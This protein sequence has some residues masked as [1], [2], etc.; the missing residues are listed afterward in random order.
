MFTAVTTPIIWSTP[1]LVSFLHPASYV[2]YNAVRSLLSLSSTLCASARTVEHELVEARVRIRRGERNRCCVRFVATNGWFV[3]EAL[4]GVL[5]G[6]EIRLNV[7]SSPHGDA[8]PTGP[9]IGVAIGA[10]T[11]TA[12][13]T[14]TATG[15]VG[16]RDLAPRDDEDDP[17]SQHSLWPVASK[18]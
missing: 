18:S 7:S 12:T 11:G 16:C 13:A 3:A 15:A 14:A 8:S 5:C 9:A 6:D 4:A 1:R 10:S 17:P 2:E